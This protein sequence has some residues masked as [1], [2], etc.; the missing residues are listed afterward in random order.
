MVETKQGEK[1]SLTH[2]PG[3]QFEGNK[4]LTSFWGDRNLL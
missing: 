2:I 4:I 3:E 1:D